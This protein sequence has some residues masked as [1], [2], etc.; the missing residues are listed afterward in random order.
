MFIFEQLT[1]LITLAV[2]VHTTYLFKK[3]SDIKQTHF[4]APNSPKFYNT[5]I[6]VKLPVENSRT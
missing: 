4:K 5:K 2:Y 3:R 1:Q 6:S